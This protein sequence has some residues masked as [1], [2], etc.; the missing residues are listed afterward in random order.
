MKIKTTIRREKF[1]ICEYTSRKKISRFVTLLFSRTKFHVRKFLNSGAY[2]TIRRNRTRSAATRRILCS[3]FIVAL[4]V[5][6]F[7]REI[8]RSNSNFAPGTI[9]LR[10][11][12]NS[13]NAGRILQEPSLGTLKTKTKM[14]RCR[15]RGRVTP[16]IRFGG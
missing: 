3:Y 11:L 4:P 7:G 10:V 2:Y 8:Y 13:G 16:T 15:A 14:K 6:E 1:H 9:N 12:I 5:V